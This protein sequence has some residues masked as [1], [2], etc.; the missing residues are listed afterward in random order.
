MIDIKFPRRY[1]P[2]P[3]GYRVVYSTSS[4]MY[5]W[6]YGTEDE[7]KTGDYSLEGYISWDKYWVRRCAFAHHAKRG[8]VK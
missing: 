8:I 6:I 7:T 5:L 3:P 1:K 4:E 2:L